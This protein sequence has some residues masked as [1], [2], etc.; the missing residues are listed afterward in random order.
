VVHATPRFAA[1]CCTLS[2]VL[3]YKA[4]LRA[5]SLFQLPTVP[6]SYRPFPLGILTGAPANAKA[7]KKTY[8]LNTQAD[9]FL[10]R[11]AGSPFPEAVDAN[12]K[13]LAE[14]RRAPSAVVTPITCLLAAL[15][16]RARGRYL[17]TSHILWPLLQ[18]SQREAAIRSRPDFAKLATDATA[19]M[20]GSY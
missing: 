13:E 17:L 14:V 9:A 6:P 18:V 15:I 2:T 7:A 1:L 16:W 19:V 4:P 11:Y 12:E 20:A 8:D 3:Q 10:S 5:F